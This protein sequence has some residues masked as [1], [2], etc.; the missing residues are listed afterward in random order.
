MLAIGIIS[1]GVQDQVNPASALLMDHIHSDRL[2]MR[3]GAI[4]GLGLAYAN[5]K[6]ET[7]TKDEPNHVIYELKKVCF[8]DIVTEL[9]HSC[10]GPR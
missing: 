7:V 6:R 1:S 8:D 3:I 10:L 2:I 4:M 5:S 9:R